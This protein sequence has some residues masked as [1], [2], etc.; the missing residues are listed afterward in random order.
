MIFGLGGGTGLPF[1]SLFLARAIKVW[2]LKSSPLLLHSSSHTGN[3]VGFTTQNC[4]VFLR[5]GITGF[6]AGTAGV[7]EVCITG[8]RGTGFTGTGLTG[9]VSILSLEGCLRTED[10]LCFS[11]D[12][13]LVP[14]DVLLLLGGV[15][16]PLLGGVVRLLREGGVLLLLRFDM[17]FV[18]LG[19]VT[20]FVVD[21]GVEIDEGVDVETGFNPCDVDEGVEV[22][23]REGVT[24][25]LLPNEGLLSCFS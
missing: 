16:R 7:G 24:P 17:L 4:S 21:E 6:V 22:G 10:C 9:V 23:F 5:P 8:L 12:M 2:K 3:E 19:V 15:G 11:S 1:A 20:V 25:L 14:D 18:E 13:K